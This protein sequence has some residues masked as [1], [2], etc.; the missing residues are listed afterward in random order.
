MPTKE[1]QQDEY[2]KDGR[3]VPE[4]GAYRKNP[5]TPAPN[6]TGNQDNAYF[7]GATGAPEEK[8]PKIGDFPTAP[9]TSKGTKEKASSGEDNRFESRYD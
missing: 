4:E 9:M 1:T 2:A 5:L 8:T 7:T 6:M 3:M